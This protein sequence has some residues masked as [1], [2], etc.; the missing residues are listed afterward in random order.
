MIKRKVLLRLLLIVQIYTVAFSVGSPKL[1]AIDLTLSSSISCNSLNHLIDSI[2]VNDETFSKNTTDI[3]EQL[4]LIVENKECES[5]PDALNLLGLIQY[6]LNEPSKAKSYLDRAQALLKDNLSK[7]E[8]SV[9]NYLFIG[10]TNQIENNFSAAHFNFEK[11]LRLSES[12]QFNRGILQA[13]LNLSLS[14]LQNAEMEK[15]KSIL[16]E[17]E[18]IVTEL[19]NK[20]LGGYVYQ[21][22]AQIFTKENNYNEALKNTTKAFDIWNEL[23]FQKGLYFCHT[24]MAYVHQ[25]KKDTAQ[26]IQALYKAIDYSGKDKSYIRHHPYASLGHYFK[27]KGNVEESQHYFEQALKQS[28]SIP[29]NELLNIINNLYTFYE[30]DNNLAKIKQINNEVLKIYSNRSALFS[31]EVKKWQNKEV[32]LEKKLE[33]NDFLRLTNFQILKQIRTRNILLGVLFIAFN[34]ALFYFQRYR[35]KE[36]IRNEKTRTELRNKIT[37]DLHDDVGTMLAGIAMQSETLELFANEKNK[38]MARELAKRSRMAMDNMR[39]TVWAMDSRSDKVGSLKIKI[40]DYLDYILGQRDIEYST[41]FD[42]IDENFYL[43]P[44]VRQ[45]AYLIFKE[46]ITNIAK[47][48]VTKNVNLTMTINREK[49]FMSIQD[50]GL[51]KETINTSG[52]GLKNMALRAEKLKGTF[53]FQ[54]NKGYRTEF[55]L[56]LKG[57]T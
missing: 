26:M 25:L 45:T 17:A 13:K 10:L 30:N 11:A 35:Y 47:H 12:I 29:E 9:R 24:S 50:Y 32:E 27:T 5:L 54:Y 36:R 44:E 7:S 14:Y 21:N 19:K 20:K 38:P 15:A 23:G 33:E 37:Q 46:S 42:L 2:F 18:K 39:D 49:I 52:Q 1:W 34:L 51:K 57:L 43:E 16:Y 6:N 40:L 3:A 55:S 22:L 41:Q 28:N 4:L 56:P 53:N 48:S 8:M 31:E